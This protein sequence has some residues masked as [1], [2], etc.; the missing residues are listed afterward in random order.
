MSGLSGLCQALDDL[1]VKRTKTS[2]SRLQETDYFNT[3]MLPIETDTIVHAGFHSIISTGKLSNGDPYLQKHFM[4]IGASGF[5]PSRAIELTGQMRRYMAIADELGIPMAVPLGHYL[6]DNHHVGKANIVQVVPRIGSDLQVIL[7]DPSMPDETALA[8]IKEYLALQRVVWE[9]G[10]PISLDPPPANFCYNNEGTLCYIDWMPP[11]QRLPDGSLL[12]ELPDPPEESRTFIEARY[13]SSLQARVIY[14]Q[15]L[16]TLA[17]RQINPDKIK[18]MIGSYLGDDAFNYIH[19]PDE[20]RDRV[21]VDPFPSDVDILR[22][23]AGEAS[24]AGHLGRVGL[25]KIYEATHILAGGILPHP[26]KVQN[27][28]RMIEY[29]TREDMR[30][31]ARGLLLYTDVFSEAIPGSENVRK[32]LGVVLWDLDGVRLRWVKSH[33]PSP[34][35]QIELLD[36]MKKASEYGLAHAVLTNRPPGQMAAIA[37]E[38]GVDYGIWVTESGGSLYDVRNHMSAVA[39]E[40][41]PYIPHV[42]RLRKHLIETIGIPEVPTGFN[43]PQFEPGMGFIKTVIVLPDGLD[44]HA[45]ARD[46]IEPALSAG[47]FA[48]LFDVKVGKAID[49]DPKGLSK[50]AGMTLLLTVNGIDPTKMPV[51]WIADAKRDIDAARA[52]TE[53]GGVVAAVGNADEKYSNYVRSVDGIVAPENTTYHSS[54]SYILREFMEF[55]SS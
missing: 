26:H 31:T 55:I 15:L 8:H 28:A 54:A 2:S 4:A 24:L 18:D 1:C 51:L 29:F 22:C 36:V 20:T 13:F 19:F 21:L 12:S 38:M 33:T 37:Y 46:V 10:F 27:A 3:C 5:E 34:N 11:R 44:L 6:E 32:P 49:I 47:G 52:L 14:A 30:S 25:G 45:Y 41:V 23:L 35:D 17:G 9:A 50:K 16:R 7:V 39:P 42:Q 40:F 53:H 48:E 43:Q